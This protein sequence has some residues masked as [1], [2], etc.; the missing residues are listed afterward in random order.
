MDAGSI[1]PH[2]ESITMPNVHHVARSTAPKPADGLYR[3]ARVEFTDGI[4]HVFVAHYDVGEGH[5]FCSDGSILWPTSWDAEPLVEQ[6][7]AKS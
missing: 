1:S 4:V 6:P 5:W 2:L 7:E 3:N